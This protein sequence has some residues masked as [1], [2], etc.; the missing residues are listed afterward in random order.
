M[1]E[2]DRYRISHQVPARE[3]YVG[4]YHDDWGENSVMTSSAGGT[5]MWS[6]KVC[7]SQSLIHLPGGAGKEKCPHLTTFD[8]LPAAIKDCQNDFQLSA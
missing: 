2:N 7:L 4:S 5:W 6:D 1:T 8:D 3:E